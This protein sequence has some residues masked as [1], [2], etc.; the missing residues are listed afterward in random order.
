MTIVE[1]D[2]RT[3]YPI[4]F[5]VQLTLT[6]LPITANYPSYTIYPSTNLFPSGGLFLA[7]IL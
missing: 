3:G 2:P 6:P 1:P 7:P 4:L 5:P